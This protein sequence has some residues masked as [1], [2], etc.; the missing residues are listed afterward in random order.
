VNHNIREMRPLLVLYTAQ[1]EQSLFAPQIKMGLHIDMARTWIRDILKRGGSDTAASTSG[2]AIVADGIINDVVR[3]KPL[4]TTFNF[5]TRQLWLLKRAIIA[6]KRLRSA[7]RLFISDMSETDSTV[8]ISDLLNSTMENFISIFHG[9]AD[10]T[11]PESLEILAL[12]YCR[13]ICKAAKCKCSISEDLLS[14]TAAAL[15]DL[16]NPTKS[17]YLVQEKWLCEDITRRVHRQLSIIKGMSAFQLLCH[18]RERERH[19]SPATGENFKYLCN[20]EL[21]SERLAHLAVVH[22]R[23]WGPLLY[24][25]LLLEIRGEG[26]SML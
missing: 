13:A 15:S 24:E 21:I 1:F 26:R 14:A 2:L 17:A 11:S 6:H 5:D 3:M 4:P 22:W 23:T 7:H 16:W 25:D 12:E 20:V 8:N 19:I 18:Q 10:P 9:L